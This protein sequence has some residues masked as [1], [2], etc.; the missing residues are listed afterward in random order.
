MNRGVINF[1]LV[2]GWLAALAALILREVP[3]WLAFAAMGVLIVIG[4]IANQRKPPLGETT[5]SNSQSQTRAAFAGFGR[6]QSYDEIIEAI[7]QKSDAARTDAER[8]LYEGHVF[9]ALFFHQGGFDY[10]FAHVDD[11]N[12]WAFA[13]GALIWLGRDDVTPIFHEAAKLYTGFDHAAADQEAT[14]SYLTQIRELDARFRSAIPDL[15]TR[16]REYSAKI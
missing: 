3:G 1:L 10:Y 15:E 7:R 12:R 11:P 9:E 13:V 2:L 4:T 6:K 8:R 14:K 5:R 16:L